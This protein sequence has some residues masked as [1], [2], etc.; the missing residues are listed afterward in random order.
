VSEPPGDECRRE[1][2]RVFR[3]ESSETNSLCRD[4]PALENTSFNRE[5]VVSLVMASEADASSSET[6]WPTS[7]AN[8]A[9]AFVKPNRRDKLSVGAAVEA[10][11]SDIVTIA[12]PLE[13]MSRMI[14]LHSKYSRT[15]WRWPDVTRTALRSERWP[16]GLSK[17]SDKRD[18]EAG[19]LEVSLPFLTNRSFSRKFVAA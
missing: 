4:T 5:R 3:R 12:S 7:W 14:D 18:L 9:S 6:P 11:R 17:N 2:S 1:P 19:S 13:N 10:P 16:R 8:A 15:S